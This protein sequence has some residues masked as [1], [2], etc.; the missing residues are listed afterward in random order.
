MSK[1]IGIV[2]A[3]DSLGRICL[4][5]ET[6]RTLGISTG[7]EMEMFVEGDTICLRKHWCTEENELTTLVSRATPE[8]AAKIYKILGV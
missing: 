6:R 4:P 8:Q 2:R 3:L 1:S 5:I 7:D